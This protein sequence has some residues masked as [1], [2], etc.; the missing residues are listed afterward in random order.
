MKQNTADVSSIFVEF[1]FS[2]KR[3]KILSATETEMKILL[4]MLV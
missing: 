3:R 2:V 1:L 4:E